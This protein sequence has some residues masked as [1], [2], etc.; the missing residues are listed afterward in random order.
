MHKQI[1]I[2]EDILDDFIELLEENEDEIIYDYNGR[3]N[4]ILIKS[5]LVSLIFTFIKKSL[6]SLNNTYSD[7][8]K[9]YIRA[10]FELEKN[11][12]IISKNGHIFIKIIDESVKKQVLPEEKNSVK[13]RYNGIKEEELL[14]F[15]NEFFQ[16]EENHSFFLDIAKEFTKR[17]L[18]EKQI[19]HDEYEQKVFAYIHHLTFEKLT[20]IYDDEDGF[21]LGFA[22][23]IFRIHFKEVFTYIAELILDE[24]ALSNPYMMEFLDYYSQD[25][26]VIDGEKYK[27][28][29]LEAD[30]GLR[31]S[32]PSMLS[33]VK[34]YT[35]AKLNILQFK[36]DKISLQNKVKKYYI[37]GLSPIKNNELLEQKKRSIEIQIEQSRRKI[38]KLHDRLD[39][40]QKEERRKIIEQD[41][42]KEE[43]TLKNLRSEKERV[44]RNIVKKSGLS[45]YMMLQK[46][47]DSISRK[48]QREKKI[49]QQNKE[50]YNSIKNSL[51]KV[52]IAKKTK[53]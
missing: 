27:V 4:Q 8:I 43:E 17:Y 23:Y 24:I 41:I 16:D 44:L 11:S 6:S 53:I 35:R 7:L 2:D 19:T 22:G 5:S 34:I 15:H 42:R 30:N 37:D 50:A 12:V 45:E 13:N 36:Q 3:S 32:V 14:A 10:A 52:L 20:E 21:F 40:T 28:P 26:L 48:L 29:H 9:A 38:N 49:L 18:I 46:E 25:V 39:V 33:I 51:V 31:W 1:T 47:L